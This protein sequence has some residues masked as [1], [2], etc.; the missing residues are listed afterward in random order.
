VEFIEGQPALRE[1]LAEGRGGRVPVGVA[2]THVG[3]WR[4]TIVS[5]R[6]GGPVPQQ[7][8]AIIQSSRPALLA[9]ATRPT[10]ISGA[11]AGYSPKTIA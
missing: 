5:G 2:D 1:V 3:R 10:I 11:V 8:P 9:A 6:P 7:L 4:P